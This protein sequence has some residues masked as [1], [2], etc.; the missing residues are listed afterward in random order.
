MLIDL[1]LFL[2]FGGGGLRERT[3]CWVWPEDNLGITAGARK[4]PGA[5]GLTN[6]KEYQATISLSQVQQCEGFKTGDYMSET[7][8][9]LWPQAHSGLPGR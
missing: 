1:D 4:G 9:A 5:L 3:K 8:Q 7:D 6:R 2:C